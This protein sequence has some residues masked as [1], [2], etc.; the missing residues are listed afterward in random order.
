MKH[1]AKFVLAAVGGILVLVVLSLLVSQRQRQ[2]D[3]ARTPA[4]GEFRAGSTQSVSTDVDYTSN[5]Q[6]GQIG[7]LCKSLRQAVLEFE[8]GQPNEAELCGLL[9][10]I[11]ELLV[12]RESRGAVLHNLT[13]MAKHN[14]ILMRMLVAALLGGLEDARATGLM[15][16]LLDTR[17]P[18]VVAWAARSVTM[19]KVDD[20]KPEITD[21]NQRLEAHLSNARPGG[22]NMKDYEFFWDRCLWGICSDYQRSLPFA[23][24]FL[25]RERSRVGMQVGM[26]DSQTAL[27]SS[28]FTHELLDAAVR[29]RVIETLNSSTD[30]EDRLALFNVVAYKRDGKPWPDLVEWYKFAAMDIAEQPLIRYD[31]LS[32]MRSAQNEQ[33]GVVFRQALEVEMSRHN[34]HPSVAREALRGIVGTDRDA[35]ENDPVLQELVARYIRSVIKNDEYRDQL[36]GIVE[37][38]R[39]GMGPKLRQR[40]LSIAD[41]FPEEAPQLRKWLE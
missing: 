16:T 24:T 35:V 7:D 12:T 1:S 21:K 17:N 4:S 13:H 25:E 33:F 29:S 30:K 37:E 28:W 10:L 20:R 18:K 11:H 34:P 39:A 36:G 32:S 14:S 9:A 41:E 15:Q 3:G 26:V 38:L 27:F 19:R 8:G 5:P 22:F 31:V 23:K 40:L 6:G 2:G